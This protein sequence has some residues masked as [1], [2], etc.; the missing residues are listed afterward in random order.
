MEG[1]EGMEKK[2]A[3]FAWMPTAMPGVGP[4][5]AAK[6]KVMGDAHVNEC[7]KRGLAG[8]AGWFFARQG[9]IAVGTP[10]ADDPVMANFAAQSITSGQ[11]LVVMREPEVAHAAD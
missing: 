4:L 7:I 8:E 9:A 10:W 3:R 1:M 2:E 6:R 5:V 11:A